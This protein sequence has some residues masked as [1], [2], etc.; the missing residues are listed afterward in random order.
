[1]W[2]FEDTG[3]RPGAYNMRY[4][5]ALAYDVA[6]G[7]HPS[8]VRVFGWNP[9][10]ISLGWN[11]SET[12]IDRDAAA[13]AGIDVVRRP[14]G[15]RAILHSEEL[16]YSVVMPANG[17]NV[18][19]VYREICLCL[20]RGLRHLGIEASWEPLQPHFPS[21]ARSFAHSICFSSSARYEIQVHG[22][23]LVGS[24]QRRFQFEG[25]EVVLQHGSILLGSGHRQIVQFLAAPS[26]EERALLATELSKKTTDLQ[27][28]LGY[29]PTFDAV[30]EAVRRG[31]EEAWNISFQSTDLPIDQATV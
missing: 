22:R 8:T 10:A 25:T 24:A 3:F 1:M 6:V 4:D 12:D 21:L 7:K 16:T 19:A 20:V 14:T 26:D 5:E 27:S 11:Q 18:S 31:F 23:K 17:K 13:R 15:G 9:P 2:T 28:L 29:Q 30:A